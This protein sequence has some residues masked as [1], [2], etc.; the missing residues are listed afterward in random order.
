VKAFDEFELAHAIPG[1]EAQVAIH[2]ADL[3]HVCGYYPKGGNIAG[4]FT[5]VDI[6]LSGPIES[7]WTSFAK[8]GNPNSAGLPVWPQFGAERNY[9]RFQQDGKQAIAARSNRES[10]SHPVILGTSGAFRKMS[11]ADSSCRRAASRVS[12]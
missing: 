10:R 1:Q 6:Q 7:D 3:P 12:L 8:T 5:D 4:S 11:N 9:I 2:G